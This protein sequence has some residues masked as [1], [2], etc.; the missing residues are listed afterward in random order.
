MN[1]LISCETGMDVVENSTLVIARALLY[2]IVPSLFAPPFF[3]AIVWVLSPIHLRLSRAVGVLTSAAAL[4]LCPSCKLQ[5]HAVWGARAIPAAAPSPAAA[6]AAAAA[7]PHSRPVPTRGSPPAGRQLHRASVACV[8]ICSTPPPHTH[9]ELEGSSVNQQPRQ[10]SGDG[11]GGSGSG[12]GG[13]GGSDGG[14][15]NGCGGRR[16]GRL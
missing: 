4:D 5:M 6:A 9:A 16:Y 2:A 12:G 1:K 14:V 15:G 13:G 3:F 10:R 8:L 7:R 11:G